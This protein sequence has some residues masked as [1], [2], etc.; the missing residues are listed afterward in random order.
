MTKFYVDALGAYLGGFDG[1]EPQAG[2]I[3]V[4]TPPS[5]GADMWVDGTWVTAVVI[6]QSVTRRQ[7]KQALLLQGLL[8]NVQPAIDAILD[9]QQR[10]LM[11][12][13]WDDSQEFVRTRTSL[14]QIG[15]ALG[16]D[17]AGL[18]ALFVQAG[19]L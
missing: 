13:E 16:L 18:D 14:I 1:A 6:P 19:G 2:A 15:A 3:E 12:I 7:A 11:Q 4:Q 17:A 9:P 8:A 10:G 5:N